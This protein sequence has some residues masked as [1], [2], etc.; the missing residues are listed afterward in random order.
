MANIRSDLWFFTFFYVKFVFCGFQKS[1]RLYIILRIFAC[2]FLVFYFFA[3]LHWRSNLAVGT[4]TEKF[5][6]GNLAL[7]T[8][9]C[10]FNCYSITLKKACN[11]AYEYFSMCQRKEKSSKV[12]SLLSHTFRNLHVRKS[13]VKH[14]RIRIF[15]SFM[16]CL[17]MF[18]FLFGTAVTIWDA[19]SIFA[20]LQQVI[21]MRKKA[22]TKNRQQTETNYHEMSINKFLNTNPNG[23]MVLNNQTTQFTASERKRETGGEEEEENSVANIKHQKRLFDTLFIQRTK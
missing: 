3:N 14:S 6:N 13:I 20:F 15:K 23:R 11:S 12:L 19:F 1:T 8:R 2:L 9:L 22:S 21:V 16:R 5:G 18:R 10:S 7:P 4:R 17:W